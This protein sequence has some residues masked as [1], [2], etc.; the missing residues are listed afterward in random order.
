MIAGLTATLSV[1]TAKPNIVWFLTD[2]QDQM[3]GASFPELNGVG[4]MPQTKAILQVGGSMATNFFIH[5]PI[6]CPSRSELLSGRYLHNIK[7]SDGSGCMHVNETTVNEATFAKYL[8]AGGYTVGMFGKYLNNVPNF[9]PP[10]FDVWMANGGGDYVHPKFATKNIN[11]MDPPSKNIPDGTN[12]DMSK[13]GN[14]STSVIGNV[15]L[16]WIRSVVNKAHTPA[17][18]S[19][20][21][22]STATAAHQPF[23]AYIAP[24][25]AHEPFNPAPWYVDHWDPAWPTH[26]PRPVNWNCSAESRAHHHGAIAT[27]PMIDAPGAAVIT[28]VF[29]NRWRTLMSVDDVIGAVFSECVKLGVAENTYFFYS[30][31]HGF[32]LGQFNILMDKRQTYDWDTRIHLLA[33][34]P[35]IQAGSTWAQPATQ[36]DLAPTFLGLA[37]LPKPPLMDGK[38]LAPL[39]IDAGRAVESGRNNDV[40][41]SASTKAHLVLLG[42]NS[43]A[44]AAGW[45]TAGEILIVYFI[46]SYE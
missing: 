28:G 2:D 20:S 13:I 1:S 42:A 32:Q 40:V 18:T 29:Q 9:V 14:Y 30:S 39:L 7:S 10:G 21:S 22:S 38:S 33:R 27:A 6:C 12:H 11:F 37:G 3:L 23:F 45:R 24:K 44:Y 4:P 43:T 31:D 16:A 15:S 34:G 26:E 36:V 41:V 8:Q 17:T 46:L 25:A 5:T 19:D 35:G